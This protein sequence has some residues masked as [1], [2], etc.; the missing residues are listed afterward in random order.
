MNKEEIRRSILLKRELLSEAER[1]ESSKKIQE[2]LFNQREFIEAQNIYFYI[3]FG[4]EVQTLQLIDKV[5]QMG[6]NVFAPASRIVEDRPVMTFYPVKNRNDLINGYCKILE[7]Q[8]CLED[9]PD[10][11]ILVMPGVAFDLQR[12]RIGY[13]KGF[14]DYFMQNCENAQISYL[15]IAL[16]FD[17]QI[18]PQ[19]DTDKNDRK[20]NIIITEKRM[21]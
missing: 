12:N 20:P 7:P 1:M 13:G 11:D 3:S 5:I 8:P 21:I 15:S 10:P 14:Y 19:I 6:K 16:A 18:V 4:S 17:C 2:T 9:S